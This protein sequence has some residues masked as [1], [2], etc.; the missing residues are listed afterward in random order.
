MS[1]SY[2]RRILGR[3]VH[4]YTSSMNG[5]RG[6]EKGFHGT[7]SVCLPESGRRIA[8]LE[9]HAPTENYG[10]SFR[11]NHEDEP[12][13]V[14]FKCG[15]FGLYLSADA[16]LLRRVRDAVIKAWPLERQAYTFSGRD[17]S[18][19]FHDHAVFWS[20]GADDMGWSSGTPRWRHGAWH[21]LGH[22]MRQGDPEVLEERDVLVPM[23]ERS[24]KGKAKLERTRWGF[25]KLPR[26]FDR[27][28]YHVTI[29]MLPGEQ[30]PF[31][32]KGENAYDC[33]DDAAF[34]MTSPGSTIEDGVGRLVA[35]VLRDRRRRGGANWRP[36]PA[37]A[38]S[39]AVGAFDGTP[40]P[41]Q[42]KEGGTK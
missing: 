31:P 13:H 38:P 41:R 36:G 25:G 5:E 28:D 26:V 6:C 12:L 8:R 42:S 15:L 34:S 37:T 10:A 20:I 21:P 22:F 29:E 17:F 32:G 14:S 11:A 16:P 18:V 19:S 2:D 40:A 4:I 7:V 33:D 30:V 39:A 27:V 24:Y 3:L 1:R 23:P 9:Y 35:S